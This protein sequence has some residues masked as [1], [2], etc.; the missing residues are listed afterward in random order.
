MQAI[1]RSFGR[2]FVGAKRSSFEDRIRSH[3]PRKSGKAER[4]P[5]AFFFE[6]KRN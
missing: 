1:A 5:K 2:A 3:C 6:T 4:F